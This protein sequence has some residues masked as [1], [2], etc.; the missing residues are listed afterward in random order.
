MPTATSPSYGI[1]IRAKYENTIGSFSRLAATI[2]QAGGS[3]GEIEIVEIEGKDI[4]RDIN[5]DCAN[6]EQAKWIAAAVRLLPQVE[7]ISVTDRTFS[8]HLGGKIEVCSKSP[9]RNREDLS[10]AYTPG[11]ARVSL[12]TS[13][14][15]GKSFALTIRRNTVAVVSDGSAVL[16]LGNI[17]PL[18]AL[19]VME[20]KAMLFKKFAGVDAFP[21]CLSTQDAE[22]IVSIVKAISP[23][24]GGINLEDI[25]APKCFEVE[26]R[27]KAE[28]D[29]P[30]FH[31]DQHGTAAV[32]LAALLNATQVANKEIHNLKVVISGAGAAGVAC[33]KALLAI[34][35][36]DIIV[37]DTRGAI[38][39]GRTE[40]MNP[41][42]QWLA[43]NTNKGAFKG[44]LKQAL[45]G[46]DLL[47]G[48]SGPNLLKGEDLKVM[49][50]NPIVF[51]LSNPVPEVMPEEAAPYV[52]V[53]ATGRSDYPNQINNVLCFPG[54]FRGLLDS[55]AMT[56]TQEMIVAASKA[57][58][59]SVS[60]EELRPD[61]II[62]SVFN[63]NVAPAVAKAVADVAREQGVV[64]SLPSDYFSAAL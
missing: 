52:C 11:V 60:A 25:A 53:I 48:V 10:M 36:A 55:F 20:G 22:D 59:S 43:E 27:L 16:G 49:A 30:V 64:R 15:P 46:A 2:A 26:E 56:V 5:V 50:K 13:D 8:M 28:L 9:L 45:K 34:G 7:I 29:I 12:A 19:P 42:K 32:V 58:A 63:A 33:S 35:V 61:Y 14:E 21:I 44:D 3:L 17:G 51:A 39:A 24:F 62:P 38:Y 41:A 1:T 57:I 23:T 47:L 31:D 6:E 54:L 18:G 4:I 40:H 37:C